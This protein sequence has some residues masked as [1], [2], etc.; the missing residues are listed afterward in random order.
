MVGIITANQDTFTNPTLFT[1]IKKLDNEG[2]GVALFNTKNQHRAPK[3]L[4]NITY[5]DGPKGYQIPRRPD[6]FINYLFLYWNIVKQIKANKINNIIAVDPV[7]LILAGRIKRI[8]KNINI[9]YFSFEI[10]FADEVK[11]NPAYVQLKKKEIYY[12]KFVSSI[13]IQD[14]ERK[15]LLVRENNINPDFTN[16]HL[17]PVAPEIENRSN[18]T[19]YNRAQ[20]GLKENDI[21]YIHSGSVAE[22]AGI[23]HIIKAVEDGLPEN[24]YIFI[25]SRTKL[26]FSNRTNAKL[27]ALKSTYPNLI[28]HDEAFDNYED[29]ISFLNIFDYGIVMY[30]P[31]GGIF[32]GTNIQEIGLSSGKFSTYMAVGLPCLLF[33]CTTYT[34]IV[35]Q[36]PIGIIVAKETGISSYI[37]NKSLTNYT[38]ENCISFYKKALDPDLKISSFI[39]SELLK[40]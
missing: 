1:L 4:N 24:T 8:Y 21:V 5:F 15:K 14:E 30:E 6:N 10:F 11:N 19:S 27:L 17:I 18:H 35:A 22:W 39:Q 32:T 28:I 3:D 16:W 2:H 34:K 25:H 33:E 23:N 26:D 38:K 13:L 9:H 29:Y 40:N 31:D 20:Y 37:K 12:S 7:G 36:Y